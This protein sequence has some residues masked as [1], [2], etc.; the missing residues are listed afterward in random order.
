MSDRDTRLVQ[1]AVLA[2]IAWGVLVQFVGKPISAQA[3]ASEQE[4]SGLV[5]DIKKY[6]AIGG[7]SFPDYEK[8]LRAHLED[9]RKDRE[10]L[11]RRMGFRVDPAVSPAPGEGTPSLA[12]LQRRVQ[13]SDR[14]VRDVRNPSEQTSRGPINVLNVTEPKDTFGIPEALP[15][16]PDRLAICALQIG[17][18]ARVWEKVLA[19][20]DPRN[21]Q[22]IYAVNEL[23][24]LPPKSFP[25]RGDHIFGSKIP[26]RLSMTM[27]L[28]AL[29]AFLAALDDEGNSLTLESFAVH[30][31]ENPEMP[32]GVTMDL[33]AISLEQVRP[34]VIPKKKYEEP[35]RH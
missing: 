16:E 33:A 34:A 35:Q 27:N 2:L 19:V 9:C 5:G 23:R 11:E 25:D 14:I 4:R 21:T 29:M 30:P 7:T 3:R 17:V 31:P 22:A 1:Q 28:R 12:V 26:V 32:L 15:P 20:N 24:V 13:L 6:L 8:Q 18:V 10:I